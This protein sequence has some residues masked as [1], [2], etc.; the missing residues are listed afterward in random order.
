M[1]HSSPRSF[2]GELANLSFSG[3]A[4]VLPTGDER[5]WVFCSSIK[6]FKFPMQV[7]DMDVNERCFQSRPGDRSAPEQPVGSVHLLYFTS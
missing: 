4:V 3:S 1:T 6:M 7:H 2:K 5:R